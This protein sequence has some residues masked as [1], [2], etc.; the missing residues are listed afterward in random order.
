M[1]KV[2][3]FF[4]SNSRSLHQFEA[5]VVRGNHAPQAEAL[6]TCCTE[7]C[8]RGRSSSNIGTRSIVRRVSLG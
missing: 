8:F 6:K 4:R 5:I 2:L 1:R 7:N 3:H